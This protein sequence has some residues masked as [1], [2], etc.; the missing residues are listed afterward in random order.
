MA[1]SILD[2]PSAPIFAEYGLDA[3]HR[4]LGYSYATLENMTK[5]V[6]PISRPFRRLACAVLARTEEELFG[7]VKEGGETA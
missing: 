3:L 6:D 2:N 4:K 5:G 1:G 7:P